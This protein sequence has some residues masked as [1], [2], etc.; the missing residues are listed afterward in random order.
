ML[1]YDV[2]PE[3]RRSPEAKHIELLLF[4]MI[5]DAQPMYKYPMNM[6]KMFGFIFV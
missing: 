3:P 6:L 2:V 1:Y 5:L 4:I